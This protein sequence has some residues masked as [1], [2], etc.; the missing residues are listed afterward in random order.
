MAPEDQLHLEQDILN[1]L[2]D[3]GPCLRLELEALLPKV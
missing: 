1:L 3:E 2:P